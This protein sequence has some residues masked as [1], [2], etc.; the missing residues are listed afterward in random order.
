MENEGIP[1]A[2]LVDE[3]QLEGSQ[4]APVAYAVPIQPEQV[5]RFLTGQASPD[6][7]QATPAFILK[8]LLPKLL[9]LLI[10]GIALPVVC[11]VFA[12]DYQDAD[13]DDC[14][15][16]D[17]WLYVTGWTQLA[18]VGLIF[19]ML[20]EAIKISGQN[21]TPGETVCL[22]LCLCCQIVVL[23]PLALFFPCWIIYGITLVSKDSEVYDG[24]PGSLYIFT[25]VYVYL[26]LA[27]MIIQCCC[28][29]QGQPQQPGQGAANNSTS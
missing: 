10:T 17:E 11:L 3:A 24:C 9:V 23:I 5:N 18:F 27:S 25:K 14:Y 1:E 26:L 8:R 13:E 22:P 4:P 6:A 28:G 2:R 12:Y 15:A 20:A 29:R 21:M 16:L 7:E 19:L